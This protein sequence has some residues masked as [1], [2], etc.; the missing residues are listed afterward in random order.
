ML[1]ETWFRCLT[2]KVLEGDELK[3]LNKGDKDYAWYEMGFFTNWSGEDSCRILCIGT[4][5]ELR[6]GLEKL[7]VTAPDTQAPQLQLRD[8]FALL[9]PL[10]DEVVRLY[11]DHTWRVTKRVRHIEMVRSV[12]LRCASISPVLI[13]AARH[14]A[15]NLRRSSCRGKS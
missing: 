14:P 7:L 8:P 12:S 15:A 11:N 5:P 9:R 4:P 10:L 3:P 2:K 6:E 1:A 13:G